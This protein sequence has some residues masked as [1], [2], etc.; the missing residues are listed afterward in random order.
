MDL[1]ALMAPSKYLTQ[2][3]P[4]PKMLVALMHKASG[5]RKAHRN[6]RR[7]IQVLGI[8]V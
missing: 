4:R 1:L 8:T 2:N 3:G 6:W 5:I 7:P